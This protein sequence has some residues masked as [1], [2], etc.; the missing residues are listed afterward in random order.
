[1]VDNPAFCASTLVVVPVKAGVF[2]TWMASVTWAAPLVD[3]LFVVTTAEQAV[4]SI[5]SMIIK[6]MMVFSYCLRFTAG[7]MVTS[8]PFY[9]TSL[10]KSH[11]LP[12]SHL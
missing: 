12:V 7:E 9:E 2:S 6:V 3:G 4:S 1:M 8:S 11:L 10:R 5:V